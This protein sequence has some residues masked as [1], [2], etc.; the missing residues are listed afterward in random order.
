[1]NQEIVYYNYMNKVKYDYHYIR[2][3]KNT[4]SIYKMCIKTIKSQINSYFSL[5]TGL[6]SFTIPDENNL[7]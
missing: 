3:K 7:P 2:K 5:G 4:K 1:M 6:Q